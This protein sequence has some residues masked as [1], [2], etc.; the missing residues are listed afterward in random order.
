[1]KLNKKARNHVEGTGAGGAIKKD[2]RSD[3]SLPELGKLVGHAT[4]PL[5]DSSL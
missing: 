4:V 1:M 5:T 3:L 2:K